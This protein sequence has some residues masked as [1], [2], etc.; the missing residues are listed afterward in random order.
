VHRSAGNNHIRGAA[1]YAVT[2]PTLAQY[3]KVKRQKQEALKESAKVTENATL[4]TKIIELREQGLSLRRIADRLKCSF[5]YVRNV[6]SIVGLRVM[7]DQYLIIELYKE[8]LTISEIARKFELTH[9]EVKA[10]LTEA[11]LYEKRRAPKAGKKRQA[12][13]MLKAGVSMPKIAAE[14]DIDPSWLR[15][16]RRELGMPSTVIPLGERAP[17][18]VEGV[19]ECTRKGLTLKQACTKCK[20]SVST[21]YKA[22]LILG[23]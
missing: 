20:T 17:S 5:G 1:M 11:G 15:A 16:I 6:V 21:Y 13:E 8:R 4:K 19:R 2:M 23:V 22:C 7:N 3:L 12:I 10:V 18:I 9:G 14:L